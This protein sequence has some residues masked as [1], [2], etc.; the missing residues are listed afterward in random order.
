MRTQS[1]N[2]AFCRLRLLLPCLPS[3]KLSKLI[4]IKL[5]TKYIDFLFQVV[6]MV[7][8]VMVEMVPG[9]MVEMVPGVVVEMVP[10]V[11]VE[12]VQVW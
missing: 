2:E 7:P 10:G 11:M 5:A 12:M 1:L 9:V 6:E 3:D 8:G 4:T